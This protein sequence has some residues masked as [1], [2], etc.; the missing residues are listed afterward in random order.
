MCRKITVPINSK[1][2]LIDSIFLDIYNGNGR[3]NSCNS[4]RDTLIKTKKKP[5]F[6]SVRQGVQNGDRFF[7]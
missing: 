7:M 4:S 1:I 6:V 3:L 5:E 2:Y